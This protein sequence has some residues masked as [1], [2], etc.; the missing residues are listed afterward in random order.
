MTHAELEAVYFHLYG[1]V[2]DD[3]DYIMETFPIVKRKDEQKF[4]EY[5]TKQVILE[6]YDAMAEAIQTGQAYQTI[7]S[8][9][10]ADPLV[11][12]PPKR[13]QES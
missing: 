8:L 4:G 10:P 1:T 12:H 9:P 5:R 13:L 3:V 7:I 6:A 11:A 2:Q